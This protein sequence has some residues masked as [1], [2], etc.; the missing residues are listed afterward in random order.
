MEH[1]T[2]W[3][4]AVCLQK[5]QQATVGLHA[6]DLRSGPIGRISGSVRVE[7]RGTSAGPDCNL[8]GTTVLA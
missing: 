8:L 5:A 6:V 1:Q 4:R 7:V 3:E 2:R